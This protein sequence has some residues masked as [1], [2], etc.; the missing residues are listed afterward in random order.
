MSSFSIKRKARKIQI[1]DD[2]DDVKESP[3][4]DPISASDSVQPLPQLTRKPFKQSS[5]R[6]SFNPN[7]DGEDSDGERS[8]QRP[9]VIRPSIG[10][11]GSLKQKKRIS[12]SRLSFGT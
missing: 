8:E 10:R 3:A 2:E 1:E 9:V 12:S 6:K 11:S 7:E 4:S 5:L